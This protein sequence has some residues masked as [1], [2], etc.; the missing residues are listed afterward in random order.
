MSIDVASLR[1][2]TDITQVVGSRVQLTQRG[3]EFVGLCPFHDDKNPSFYVVPDKGFCHCF[4]CGWSGDSIEFLRDHDGLDFKSA[5]ELLDTEKW[6]ALPMKVGLGKRPKPKS[7]WVSVKPPLDNQSP[8]SFKHRTLGEPVA[9]WCYRDSDGSTL[10]YDARYELSDQGKI[11]KSILTWSYGH[12]ADV[13]ITLNPCV[14]TSRRFNKPYPLYGLDKLALKPT[15]QVI[16]VSGCKT[17][18]AAQILFPASISVTWPGGD[19]AIKHV[20]WKPIDGREVI[21]IPDA[22]KSCRDAFAYLCGVLL[23]SNCK[24]KYIDPESDRPSGWDLADAL[25]DNWTQKLAL[26]WARKL[27]KPILCD[28]IKPTARPNLTVVEMQFP[29]DREDIPPTFSDDALAASFARRHERHLRYVQNWG[30]WVDWDGVLWRGDETLKT[31]HLVRLMC[32]EAVNWDHGVLLSEAGKRCVASAKTIT[33]V[34]RISKSAREFA[35]TAEIWDANPWILSTPQGIIELKTG[36]MR[37]ARAEDFCTR[38]TAIS[39]EGQ[40]PLW[41]DFVNHVTGGD[42]DLYG[43]LQR[44]AGYSLTGVTSEHALAFFY[45]TGANGKSVFLDTLRAIMG[46]YGTVAPM[47]MF[48]ESKNDRH[49]TEVADLIGR[50]L[51]TSQE[52]NEGRRWD[53]AKIK[54][55]TAAKDIKA[56]FM[57]QDFFTFNPQFKLM[58][59][60]NHKPMLRTVDESIRRRVHIVPFLVT[61]SPEK[62]DIHL[63][64]KLKIEWPG[65][66]QWMVEGC[67]Q[68]QSTGLNPSSSIIGATAEYLQGED[69][70]IQWIDECCNIKPSA[71]TT[72]ALLYKSWCEWSEKCGESSGSQRKFSQKMLAHGYSQSRTSSSRRFDGI[73][74]RHSQPPSS[75]RQECYNERGMS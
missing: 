53:E 51:V 45:G 14:W 48:Q 66:L 25:A 15:A 33:A 16:V 58:F 72:V 39:P 27:V 42:A 49:S 74:L 34:E 22:D 55:M 65:I 26:D 18:D 60:G 54:E 57:R 8:L 2:S 44:F 69:T 29:E 31:L 36:E 23:Q 37:P 64:D 75:E 1:L 38:S 71:A 73:E 47:E 19:Q 52:T 30:K 46:A 62:R 17:A 21:L 7:P 68:W 28:P 4:G 43:Y 20:D 41:I 63:Y 9:T 35:A 61:I 13:D 3:S 24:L 6:N 56:R 5:C 70:F 12:D 67:L 59:A 50:R 11:T 40:C 32:R 10:G